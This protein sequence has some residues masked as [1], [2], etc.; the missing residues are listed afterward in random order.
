VLLDDEVKRYKHAH[1]LCAAADQLDFAMLMF[2][3]GEFESLLEECGL[4][5]DEDEDAVLV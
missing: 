3:V 1:E 4:I 5:A 2:V